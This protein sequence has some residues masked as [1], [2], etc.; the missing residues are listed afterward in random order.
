MSEPYR[1]PPMLDK[2]LAPLCVRLRPM[3][4][5]EVLYISL[6][7]QRPF[8]KVRNWPQCILTCPLSCKD[9][10][11]LWLELHLPNIKNIQLGTMLYRL[12]DGNVSEFCDT[13]AN[14][15]NDLSIQTNKELLILGDFT[16]QYGKTGDLNTIKLTAFEHLTNL[17]QKITLSMCST[18]ARYYEALFYNEYY[19]KMFWY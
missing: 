1:L 6:C 13:L 9:I 8:S 10:E 11:M 12:P 15:V 5:P 16:I 19:A 14:T 3:V 7:C 4:T 18:L 2:M 17:S